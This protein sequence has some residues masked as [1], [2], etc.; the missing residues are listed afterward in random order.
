MALSKQAVQEILEQKGFTCTNLSEY[1]NLDTTLH[2]ECVKGHKTD[3]P[4]RVIRDERFKC[5][6][7]EGRAS[8][9]SL[10]SGNDIPPKNG[11]RIVAIDN[12]TKNVGIA[13]YDNGK[14][15]YY[16]ALHLEGDT[17][18]RMAANRDF[19]EQVI[20]AQ[21]RPDL[22]VVEDIQEQNNLALYKTLAMLLGNTLV[23]I[24]KAGVKH[25][26]VS[27]TVWRAHFLI[28]GTR[29]K[30][31][32]QAINKVQQ[33]FGMLVTDD[34]A[35]AILIGKYAADTINKREPLTLF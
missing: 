11:K 35:E 32:I 19:L 16:R 30:E 2:I 6:A 29:E 14:L 28:K 12:A 20:L 24:T 13:V 21:W 8:V 3:A 33:M 26:L 25:Q 5:L 27:A 23:S 1:K 22:V 10:I 17:F 4:L 7:C 34:V 18:Q 9:A 31:K 15:A